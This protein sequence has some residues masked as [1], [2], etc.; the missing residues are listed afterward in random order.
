MLLV[1]FALTCG[2]STPRLSG[3][4]TP[5]TSS[6][7]PLSRRQ[8]ASAA[9]LGGLA[10]PRRAAAGLFGDDGPQGEFRT[11]SLAELRLNDLASKLSSDEVRGESDEGAIVVLQTLAV[12]FSS[13]VQTMSKASES[14][15]LLDADEREKAAAL[16]TGLAAELERTKQ[17]CRDRK[18]GAQLVGVQRASAIIDEYLTLA[19]SKYK[20]Q[21]AAPPPQ[22]SKDNKEFMSQYFG[23]FSCEGQGLE[24]IPGSNSCKDGKAGENKNPLP[25]RN[26]L[27]PSSD[28]LT[29]KRI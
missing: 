20:V 5:C 15:D 25:S 3:L 23:L 11:L 8:F 21:A 27:S 19:G 7:S 18:A 13:T 9:A 10:F 2:L 4:S 29:G 1:P 12:Q 26:F 16:A 17:G 6:S 24:R 22:Y 14:M 28:V